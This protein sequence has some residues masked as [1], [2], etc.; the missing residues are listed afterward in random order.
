MVEAED[1]REVAR[2]INDWL[3][4]KKQNGASEMA[5]NEIKTEGTKIDEKTAVKKGEFVMKSRTQEQMAMQIK[6]IMHE[7]GKGQVAANHHPQA[8]R[9]AHDVIDLLLDDL[10]RLDKNLFGSI[11]G[12]VGSLAADCLVAEY[13]KDQEWEMWKQCSRDLEMKAVSG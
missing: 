2:S 5:E 13:E 6:R 8:A 12:R 9:F 7:Y 10:S 3:T 1:L 4:I 11:V